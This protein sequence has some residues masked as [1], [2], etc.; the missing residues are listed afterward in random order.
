MAKTRCGM[1]SCG[2]GQLCVFAG[3]GLPTGPLQPGSTFIKNTRFTDG[4][5]WTNE[6]HLY[7][8]NGGTSSTFSI[9]TCSL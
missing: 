4:R 1:V 6:L 3:Y 8:I 5:G 9:G 2:E 7:D